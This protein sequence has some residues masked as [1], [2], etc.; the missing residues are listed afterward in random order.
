MASLYCRETWHSQ[1][2]TLCIKEVLKREGSE[3]GSQ[4]YVE[5]RIIVMKPGGEYA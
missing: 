2:S 5:H 3:H 4:A 1:G